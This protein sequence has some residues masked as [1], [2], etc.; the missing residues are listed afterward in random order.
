MYIQ[1]PVEY[2]KYIYHFTT[3]E[4]A[5]LYI[6]P[7]LDLKLSPYLNT[8]DPK[9]NQTFGFESIFE[10]CDDFS[11]VKLKKAF[12]EFLNNYCK[13]ICFSTDYDFS[14][15]NTDF[16]ISGAISPTM[17]AHYGN[18]YKGICIVL[19]NDTFRSENKNENHDLFEKINYSPYLHF[20][21]LDQT[22]WERRQD[23]YFKEFLIKNSKV[24]FFTKHY[25]WQS[26]NEKRFVHFGS[27]KFCSIK[28]SIVGVFVGY[29]F[30][31]RLIGLIKR[32]L[33]ND[34][35]IGKISIIDGRLIPIP[36]G[37]N[38]DIN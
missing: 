22:E 15:N 8:N 25:H 31:D 11:K 6:L 28:N 14:E 7:S 33:P 12:K 18:N 35:W 27:K 10:N 36:Y 9:E 3:V 38:N 23:E 2:G 19:C 24:F 37:M 1:M 16:L 21:L 5:L 29:D 17:W 34:R 32:F 30:D 4:M 13:L 26:E 20:P